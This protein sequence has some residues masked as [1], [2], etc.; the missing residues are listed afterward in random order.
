MTSPAVLTAMA[1]LLTALGAVGWNLFKG[2]NERRNRTDAERRRADDL[3]VSRQSL[4]DTAA[5]TAVALME[6]GA[7][8]VRAEN[9]A[10][11]GR[12]ARANA[13]I[14]ELEVQMDVQRNRLEKELEARDT[15]IARLE[16]TITE[17]RATVVD[18]KG[19]T[20]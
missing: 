16:T 19:R 14:S 20:R 18:L 6:R 9:E 4:L 17:L 5:Q 7:A 3:S 12:L 15:T 2:I 13:R 11:G 10:L 8:D 1:A